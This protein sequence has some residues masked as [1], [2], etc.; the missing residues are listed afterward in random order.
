MKDLGQ[1][2]DFRA[3]VDLF[4][5]SDPEATSSALHG[6]FMAFGLE[7]GLYV[8][9]DARTFRRY[10]E[11]MRDRTLEACDVVWVDLRERIASACV[12]QRYA[13][14]VK[15]TVLTGVATTQGWRILTA[16]FSAHCDSD[17]ARGRG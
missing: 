16:T 17:V 11:A 7:E 13:D 15:T 4:L 10:L 9:A 6:D 5:A 3:V 2:R 14:T 12:R 8:K 1:D